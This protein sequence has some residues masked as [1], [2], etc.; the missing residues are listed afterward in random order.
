MDFQITCDSGNP[1]GALTF[2]KN[3]TI[4][5]DVFLSI[6]V[7]KGSFFQRPDF[8]SNL[9]KINKVSA[10]TINLATQYIQQALQWLINVG[11]ATAVNVLVEK[12]LTALG[13]MDILVTVTQAN[14]I[15]I[16]YQIFKNVGDSVGAE[17]FA[18]Q[19]QG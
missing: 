17:T 16:V 2:L 15:P 14:G 4:A 19:L 12:D 1:S 9:F 5:T 11:K 10:Q 3:E 13:Q 7:K 6:F 18:T 8:G